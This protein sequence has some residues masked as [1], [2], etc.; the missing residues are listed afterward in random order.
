[1]LALKPY[2]FKIASHKTP[3]A[4]MR[5]QYNVLWGNNIFTRL[6]S[7]E[8]NKSHIKHCIIRDPGN[9]GKDYLQLLTQQDTTK[10]FGIIMPGDIEY[11][12]RT[13]IG[14]DR[15]NGISML[16]IPVCSI[17]SHPAPKVYKVGSVLMSEDL[18]NNKYRCIRLTFSAERLHYIW[19]LTFIL[20]TLAE[21]SRYDFI[22]INK[23]S[24]I[25]SSD[26][27]NMNIFELLT[28]L[29]YE[30]NIDSVIVYKNNLPTIEFL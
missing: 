23:N 20:S 4:P 6:S 1:M 16:Q 18:I 19:D 11:I 10:G 14:A 25:L 13:C 21:I 5:G 22:I 26:I 9:I 2:I 8:N 17:E 15:F 7:D 29:S 24:T 12:L 30:I 27:Y 3:C 28:V